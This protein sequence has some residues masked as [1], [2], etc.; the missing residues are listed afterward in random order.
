MAFLSALGAAPARAER[1]SNALKQK[2]AAADYFGTPATGLLVGAVA[3]G[4]LLGASPKAAY[5]GGQAGQGLGP[6]HQSVRK[7]E[8]TFEERKE[9]NA[10]QAD[11][12]Q[13]EMDQLERNWR[14]GAGRLSK[15]ERMEEHARLQ[16]I[17]SRVY[18]EYDVW[19]SYSIRDRERY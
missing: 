19:D 14:E 9:L 1:R 7:G 15:A 12:V 5:A 3:V 8:M 18:P 4:L 6:H 11:M 2:E 16:D 10:K 17:A 13:I